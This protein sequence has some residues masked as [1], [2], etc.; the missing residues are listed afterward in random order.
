MVAAAGS[1]PRDTNDYVER[2]RRLKSMLRL[3]SF[4]SALLRQPKPGFQLLSRGEEAIAVGVCA[5]LERTDALL[6]SGRSIAIA[7][8]RGVPAGGLL[9]ELIGKDGGPNRGRAGRA[10]VSMPSIGLFGAHGVVGGNISVAAG[11]ALAQQQ[12]ASTA[13]TCCLFGDG[14]CGAGVLHETLNIAALWRLPL[15]LACV[16]NGYAVSTSVR[17]GLAPAHLTDLAGPFGIPAIAVDGTDV[18]AVAA[19]IAGAVAKARAG[20]GAFFLELQCARLATHST[21]TREE[22]SPMQLQQLCDR[23]PLLLYERR[24]RGEA[25]LDDALWTQL[26]AEVDADIAD[27]ERF[28]QAAPW[29]DAETALLDA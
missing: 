11:V 20:Q 6:C 29:P 25:I 7:L 1:L 17:E 21:L 27:A 19:A 26:R 9:A 23:D 14:A 16:N 10:H 2:L 5:A 8:A 28:A 15:L 3:R 4:E 22:R 12:L 18:D 13:V 24:L